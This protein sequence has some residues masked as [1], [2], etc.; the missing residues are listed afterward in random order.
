MQTDNGRVSTSAKTGWILMAFFAL[1]IA[2]YAFA[3]VTI[4]QRMYPPMLV[5]SFL[6]RPWG[7]NPHA[8]FGGIALLTGVLQFHRGIRR[9]LPVHRI[10]GRIYVISCLVIGTAGIYMA[11]Y[12][13]GGWITHLGF[14]TLGVLLLLT[15]LAGYLAIRRHDVERHRDWMIRSYALIFAAVTLRIELPLLIASFGDFTPAYLVVSWLCWVPNA[16]VGE[17]LVRRIRRRESSGAYAA[18]TASAPRLS[19]A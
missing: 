12:S 15:T 1:P 7:I 5:D 17:A 3:Y 11:V 6:A 8:L 16:I 19:E 9:H 4:G 10:L 2:L 14:G 18:A 13:F